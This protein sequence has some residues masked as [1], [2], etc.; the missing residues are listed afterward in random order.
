MSA[1]A[2]PTLPAPWSTPERTALQV[3]A[4]RFA[5][6]R[7][8]PVAD[9]LDPQRAD[10]P[11]DVLGEMGRHG[12]FGIM[13]PAE[14]GGLGG[15]VFEYCLVS[16]ELARAWL[17]AASIIARAQGL[18]TAVGDPQRRRELLARSA[19]GA[20]IGAAAFSEP[21]AGSD[22]GGVATTAVRD[23]EDYLVS[24]HKRWCG[25][26]VAADFIVVLCR[27]EGEPGLRTLLLEKKPGELPPGVTA[28]PIDKIGYHGMTTYD[29]VLDRVRVPVSARV[30]AFGMPVARGEGFAALERGLNMARVQTAARAVGVARAAVED[31]TAYLQ[32][33]VQFGRPIGEFQALRFDLATM[34]A[35]VD[36]AR[37]YYRQVAA[38]MDAG[39]PCETEAAMVKLLATEMAAEVTAQAIQLHGGNGYTTEHQ[40]ERYW[41]DA[42]LTTIFEGTSQIQQLIISDRM[43][44]RVR[45]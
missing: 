12:W 25:N 18:G 15:G 35:R 9:E 19:R 17:S 11:A 32:Q 8:K 41:R 45:S 31:T 10:I 24:G 2:G 5:L 39:E 36:Q 37:A 1:L 38:M 26:A 3:E 14:D 40:V 16:E 42:R 13:I 29:L 7:L 28:T 21:D 33:R 30:E 44:G 27:I 6:D 34:A 22:L 43:L 23:G 4:R 20:W